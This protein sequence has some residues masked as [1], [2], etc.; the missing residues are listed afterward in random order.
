MRKI[1]ALI[2]AGALAMLCFSGVSEA[3]AAIGQVEFS[4]ATNGGST[5]TAVTT[6]ATG[7][8]FYAVVCA[9]FRVIGPT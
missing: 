3:A 1:Y 4:N 2:L 5:T 6:N 9:G 7:S 8:S